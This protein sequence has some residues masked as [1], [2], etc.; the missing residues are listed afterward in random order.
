MFGF[1]K[2]FHFGFVLKCMSCSLKARMLYTA[3]CFSGILSTQHGVLAWQACE[4]H[5]LIEMRPEEITKDY[6]SGFLRIPW[7]VGCED[8]HGPK[9]LFNFY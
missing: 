9:V 1:Q 4:N 3:R 5:L 7:E 6:L 8:H 2:L